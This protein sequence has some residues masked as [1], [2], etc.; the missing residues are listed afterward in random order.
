MRN[1][2]V[3]FGGFSL[4]DD[5]HG[6]WTLRSTAEP[7]YPCRTVG[8]LCQALNKKA[9]GALADARQLVA[10]HPAVLPAVPPEDKEEVR[11]TD[12]SRESCLRNRL[13]YHR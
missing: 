4:F 5:A 12:L 9:L 7:W 8:T 2:F 3:F 10:G 6:F 11:R 13:P 1:V